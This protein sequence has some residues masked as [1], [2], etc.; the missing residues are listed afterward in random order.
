MSKRSSRSF[1]FLIFVIFSCSIALCWTPIE[2]LRQARAKSEMLA[3]F[4]FLSDIPLPNSAMIEYLEDGERALMNGD[5]VYSVIFQINDAD[6]GMLLQSSP[7]GGTWDLG[8]VPSKIRDAYF[9]NDFKRNA[10]W[11][12]AHIVHTAQDRGPK[13]MP[14]HNGRIFMVDRNAKRVWFGEWDY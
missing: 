6:L 4:Q 8:P 2:R 10:P 3:R 12:A 11:Q 1:R 14:W 7:F 13:G 9:E 5:G